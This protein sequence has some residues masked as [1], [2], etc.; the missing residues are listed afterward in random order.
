VENSF[1]AESLVATTGVDFKLKLINI[2]GLVN[3]LH[4]WDTAGQER[5]RSI[6]YAY[7][8]DSHAIIFV[9]DV[10]NPSSF[11]SLPEWLESGGARSP[12]A[13][14]LLV[15]NKCDVTENRVVSNEEAEQFAQK[16]NMDYMEIS[17]KDATNVDD[18][19]AKLVRALKSKQ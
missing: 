1:Q 17:A 19:L 4:I 8:S 11:A 6:T 13:Y 15:G 10:T 5:F 2:D 16:H 3:K 12:D 18:A 14:K 7:S 9:F